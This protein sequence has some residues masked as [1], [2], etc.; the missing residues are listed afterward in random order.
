[1][2][3]LLLLLLSLLYELEDRP[4]DVNW[5]LQLELEP[6]KDVQLWRLDVSLGLSEAEEKLNEFEKQRLRTT[7][8][9]HVCLWNS[10]E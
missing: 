6:G 3:E 2:R 9:T 7:L 4:L 10:N 1:M 8:A 5:I